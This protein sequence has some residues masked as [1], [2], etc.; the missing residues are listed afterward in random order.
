MH[1]CITEFNYV[2]SVF[3]NQW[4]NLHNNWMGPEPNGRH[5]SVRAER[6]RGICTPRSG[7]ASTRLFMENAR[8]MGRGCVQDETH[9]QLDYPL[10]IIRDSVL[11]PEPQ[12]S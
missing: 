10:S 5:M 11:R 4:Q 9:T 6:R 7:H 2:L 3:E 8:R 12:S 1:I